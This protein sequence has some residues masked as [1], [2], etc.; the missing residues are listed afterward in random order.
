[1]YSYCIPWSYVNDG[2]WNCPNGNDEIYVSKKCKHMCLHLGNVCDR[3]NAYPDDEF[4]CNLS[5]AAC[6]QGCT[7]LVLA[8]QCIVKYYSFQ[9]TAEQYQFLSV[10]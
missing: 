6:P 3:I 1:M 7:C 8:I 10:L 2:I 4:I 9:V 5:Q